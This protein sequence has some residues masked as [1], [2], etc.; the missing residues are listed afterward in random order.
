ML[1]QPHYTPQHTR[2]HTH[3]HTHNWQS[4][5][6]LLM[7]P[8]SPPPPDTNRANITQLQAMSNTFLSCGLSLTRTGRASPPSVTI[9]RQTLF[10]LRSPIFPH[11]ALRPWPGC[12]SRSAQS[13]SVWHDSR[14][15]YTAGFEIKKKR[16]QEKKTGR[17][18]DTKGEQWGRHWFP[19][20]GCWKLEQ[21][22]SNGVCSLPYYCSNPVYSVIFNTSE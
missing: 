19:N 8:P 1:T 11:S 16:K 12:D 22:V 10:A 9:Q 7:Q 3:M 14:Y 21:D 5:T 17:G 2:T 13:K 6:C 15:W 18:T 20:E 4:N